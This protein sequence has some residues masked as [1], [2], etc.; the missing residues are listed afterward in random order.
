MTREVKV[1]IKKIIAIN[2]SPRKNKN[3]AQLLQEALRGAAEQGAKT[4]LVHLYDLNFHGCYSCFACK[5]LGSSSFGKCVHKDDLLP[6]LQEIHTEAD[7]LLMGAPIYFGHLSADMLAFQE[8]FFFPYYD[9]SSDGK[10]LFPRQLPNASIYT[11]NATS[12]DVEQYHMDTTLKFTEM[13]CKRFLGSYCEL[14]SYDTLQFSDYSKYA[15]SIFD[16]K[17]KKEVHDRDFPQDLAKA[18]AL[19]KKLAE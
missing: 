19:G 17:H 18:Y 12:Q 11:M 9:Y 7:G 15:S 14:L 3:T 16:E 13:M 5:R 6:L 8:R 10:G 1:M 4:K 2:G